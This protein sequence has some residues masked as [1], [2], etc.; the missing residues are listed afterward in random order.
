MAE[1]TNH[2]K[3]RFYITKY[4]SVQQYGIIRICCKNIVG[5][6]MFVII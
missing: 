1:L 2:S 4:F 3:Q 6:V 5:I